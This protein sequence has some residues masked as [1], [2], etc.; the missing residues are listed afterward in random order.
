M[1]G[2]AEMRGGTRVLAAA[3]RYRAHG[4]GQLVCWH[5]VPEG[6][7]DFA[8]RCE[9]ADPDSDLGKGT[10]LKG[11]VGISTPRIRVAEGGAMHVHGE[12][13]PELASVIVSHR[14]ASGKARESPAELIPIGAPIARRLNAPRPFAYFVGQLPASADTCRGIAVEGRDGSG[15]AVER[16]SAKQA[17]PPF[18]PGRVALPGTPDCLGRDALRSSIAE[19]IWVSLSGLRSLPVLSSGQL[20]DLLQVERSRVEHYAEWGLLPSVKVGKL[21]WFVRAEVEAELARLRAGDASRHVLDL[22]ERTWREGHPK[23]P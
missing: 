4:L 5:L 17:A 3:E 10:P 22:V 21:D 18:Q 2:C 20:G 7:R 23:S 12:A 9:T 15:L 14:T 11:G 6:G 19:A 16:Q 8:Y 1:V 13:G